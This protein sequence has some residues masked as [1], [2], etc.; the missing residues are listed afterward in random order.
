MSPT[1]HG[2][3]SQRLQRMGREKGLMVFRGSCTIVKCG[4]Y[5]C[6]EVDGEISGCLLKMQV[7]ML[8]KMPFTLMIQNASVIS[9]Q[10]LG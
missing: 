2:E 6:R 3:D 1:L 9:G 10:A 7:E 5:A 8:V 4:G